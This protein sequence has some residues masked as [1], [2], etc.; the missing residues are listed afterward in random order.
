MIRRIIDGGK[1]FLEILR[2]DEA[3]KLEIDT[4]EKLIKMMHEA[5]IKG[6]VSQNEA[7]G[8]SGTKK[9]KYLIIESG[10]EKFVAI[11][12]DSITNLNQFAGE[13]LAAKVRNY[14][15]QYRGTVLPLGSTDK[16]YM[17]REAEG[18]YTNPAKELSDT[19]YTSKLNAASEITNLLSSATFVRHEND[20][21]RHKDATRGWNYYELKY[22]IPTS[23]GLRAYQGEVQI[24]L[25]ERG[26]VFYDITKIKDITSGTA[27][28]A[29]I[30]AAGSAYGVS[31]NSIPQS[32]KKS[33]VSAKKS[34]NID[35]EAT[36]QAAR[37]S[38]ERAA[39]L[40]RAF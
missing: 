32:G 5:L 31:N 28:Q 23:E 26:D 36:E 15:K 19:D 38:A 3:G 35:T 40:T 20:N 22:V 6:E 18:E 37:E 1:A 13:S 10:N 24:K 8:E 12:P 25:I 7:T 4:T 39:S 11:E 2:A 14:L 27:G 34:H 9:K 30:K 29:L 21:G 33:T 16:A 17:R